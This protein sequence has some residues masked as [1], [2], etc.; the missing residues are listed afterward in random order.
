[1][2]ERCILDANGDW[3]DTDDI[4][5]PGVRFRTSIDH[6]NRNGSAR[7]CYAINGWCI[8]DQRQWGG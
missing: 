8:A 2:R 3:Y 6:R 7:L 4:N 5:Q 1:M